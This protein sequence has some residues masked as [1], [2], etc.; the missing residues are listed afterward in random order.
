MLVL[1]L[2]CRFSLLK[3][4]LRLGLAIGASILSCGLSAHE[5]QDAV[6]RDAKRL[7]SIYKNVHANPELPFMEFETAALIASELMANG[8]AVHEGIGGT[9]VAGVL[10]NGEGP[11]VMFRADMDALAVREKT[12][13][14]YKSTVVKA[15]RTAYASCA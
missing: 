14:S 6:E 15:D 2:D 8:F 10:E 11:I 1:T 12:D 7:V 4:T 3:C 5:I 13:L 9:G